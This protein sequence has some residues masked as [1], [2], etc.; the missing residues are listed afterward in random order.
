[1]SSPLDPDALLAAAETAT[2]LSDWG[3]PDFRARFAVSVAAIRDAGMDADGER[4]AA[5]NTHWLLTDRLRFF[6]DH[7]TYDL[8]AEQI[9]RPLFV[10]GEPRSGTTLL[11]ALLSVDPDARA[12]RFWEVMHPSP[13]PGLAGEGDARRAQADEEWREIN[14]RLPKWLH[15]HPYNDML[16]NGLPEDERTWAFD[17]RVMTPTAWWRVPMGMVVASL[18]P[19]AAAQYRIHK[20]ML[21]AIQHGRPQRYWVLKGFHAS[22]FPA[23]FDCYP[24]A[25]VLYIHR[26]PVQSI[27]S[28]I[29]M[30]ADLTEGLTGAV[31]MAEQARLHTALG[32]AGFHAVLN[33][34]MIDD[35]RVHHVRY[36]DFMADQVEVIRSFYAFAGRELSADGAV[37]MQQYLAN[38]RGDRHG[39][40]VYSTQ[41]IDGK[42]E[43]L[44]AE[45]APYRE[46][47]GLD[48]EQR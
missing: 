6:N 23:L 7:K 46:R 26:D 24:D 37:A 15:C 28:R 29:Q 16:G 36:P 8:D 18:P 35:P 27:A 45:F 30:A 25:R 13:P 17:F 12:L 43:D 20:M 2:G 11:H 34:P 44:H 5:G 48:I 33:N 47:F 10:T 32:R 14:A 42:L 41:L 38:N 1:M 3:E 21:Q 4:A 31:D 9:D 40:F 19:D 22:R 39:K